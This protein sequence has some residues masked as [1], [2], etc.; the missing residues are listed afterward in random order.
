MKQKTI[1]I[2]LILFSITM[3]YGQQDTLVLKYRRM[4]VEYQQS[5]KMAQHNLAGAE[6]MVEV[7]K[8]DFLP[9]ID[10]NGGYTYLGVPIQLASSIDG[11]TGA[12]LQNM[13]SLGVGVIQK[14]HTGGYLKNTRSAAQSKAEM[15]N[16]FISLSEQ[17]VMINS[18]IYYWNAVAKKEINSLS[19]EYRDAIGWFQKVIQDK[20]D[21][22]I[23]GMN[24]LYQARVRYDDAEYEVISSEKEFM[25]GIMKLNRSVGLPIK[26]PSSISDSLLVVKWIRVE[27]NIV[28]KAMKQR[29]EVSLLEN[30]ISMNTFNEKV[31]ASKYN[32]KLGVGVGGNWGAP[33]PG[34]ETSPAF[35]YNLQAKLAI[36]IY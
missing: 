12:E 26:S 10:L 31:T 15:M 6:S 14:V 21:D 28:E 34:L 9:K 16:Q 5:V 22:E 20:V 35:N 7:A 24:E 2:I 17:D 8:S 25:I 1:S 33:S 29:P 18:D 36:P 32:P 19:I 11:Q 23:V 27:D 4:A 13:Y 30:K 3:V